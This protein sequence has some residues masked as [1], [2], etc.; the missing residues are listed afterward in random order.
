MSP[1]VT[2]SEFAILRW[3]IVAQ[4]SGT[5]SDGGPCAYREVAVPASGA[6]VKTP[7]GCAVAFRVMGREFVS[8]AEPGHALALVDVL[9]GHGVYTQSSTPNS[10][11]AQVYLG[12]ADSA[13][14]AEYEALVAQEKRLGAGA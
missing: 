2:G 8:F 3:A 12:L 9:R 6:Y 11:R 14:R 7:G 4:L 1:R 13:A 5:W 10:D